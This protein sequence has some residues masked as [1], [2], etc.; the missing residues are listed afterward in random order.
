V[1]DLKASAGV[2]MLR[3]NFNDGVGMKKLVIN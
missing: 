1:V 2:Y 3:M